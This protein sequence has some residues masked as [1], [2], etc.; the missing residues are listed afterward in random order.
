MA[1]G[2][3]AA[4][5]AHMIRGT[6]DEIGMVHAQRTTPAPEQSAVRGV[7][8]MRPVG[9]AA[10]REASRRPSDASGSGV[11]NSP[12]SN[13][14]ERSPAHAD[15]NP[16]PAVSEAVD[17]SSAVAL[18]GKTRA[19]PSSLGKIAISLSGDASGGGEKERRINV[20]ATSGAGVVHAESSVID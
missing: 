7:S 16:R 3:G 14:A 2:N 10:V 18:D 13:V 6:V 8:A 17:D 20:A 11:D 4:H 12:T 5:T 19:V 9:S 1:S 15:G